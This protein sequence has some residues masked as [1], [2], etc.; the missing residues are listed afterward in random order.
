MHYAGIR[1]LFFYSTS[2]ALHLD[3]ISSLFLDSPTSRPDSIASICFGFFC[4]APRFDPFFLFE[5]CCIAPRFDPFL[6]FRVLR[7]HAQIL[8]LRFVSGSPASSP[9]S[10]PSFYFGFSCIAPGFV[11]F[12]LFPRF[13]SFLLFWV[14]QHSARI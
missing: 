10:I 7:H 11:P 1:S 14:L 13:D 6:L 5:F 2:L 9:D 12:V 3:A 8:S 4:I